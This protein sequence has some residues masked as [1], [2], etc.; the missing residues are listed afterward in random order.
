[1]RGDVI[2]EKLNRFIRKYYKNQLI[3]GGIYSFIALVSF[4]L[5]LN[6]I[7]YFGYNSSLVRSILFYLFL[8][9]AIL[10]LYFLIIIPLLRLFNLKKNLSHKD[11]ARIIGEHFPQIDDKLLNLLQLKDISLDEPS[12]ILEASIEQKT[13]ELS[14]IAFVKA[15]DFKKNKKYVKWIFVVVL[16]TIVLSLVFPNFLSE[17]TKRYI[18]YDK[19]F[20]KP[21]PFSFVLLNKNLKVLKNEDIEILVQIKG[22]YLVEEVDIVIEGNIF[23][24]QKEKKD[25]FSYK[26]KNI[27]KNSYFF[28]QASGFESKKYKI[29][30]NPKPILRS[31]KYRIIPPSYTNIPPSQYADLTN[32][33]I[34]KGS[35]V[36]WKAVTSTTKEVFFSF[37][38]K[39]EVFNPDNNDV[40]EFSKKILSSFS[41]NITTKNDYTTFNDSIEFSISIIEDNYPF[42]SVIK[43]QDS[44]FSDMVYFWGNIK[45]DYGFSRLEFHIQK[46]TSSIS[47][48]DNRENEIKINIPI[49]KGENIQEFYYAYNLNN[50]DIAQGEKA[51][52]YFEI[53]D[54]DLINGNKATRSSVFTFEKPSK[55]SIDSLISKN[56][57]QIKSSTS[58]NMNQLKQIQK[59]IEDINKRML[60]KKEVS[61][62]DKKELNSLIEKQEQVKKILDELSQ[63]IKENNRLDERISS[64]KSEEIIN[65]EKELEK[66]YEEL[67][68]QIDE[69][70]KKLLDENIKKE[71]IKNILDKLQS[72]NKHLEKEL[73]RALEMF[74]RLEVEKKM[75]ETINKLNSLSKEQKELSKKTKEKGDKD[76]LLKE[77]EK[78]N[79]EFEDIKKDIKDIKQKAEKLEETQK[80]E[81]NKEKQDSISAL[82]K[83]IQKQLEKNQ[84]NKASQNQNKAADKMEEMANSLSSQMEENNQEQLAE[85]VNEVRQL[86]KNLIK[87]SFSQ[88]ELI[89]KVRQTSVTDPLY[90]DIINKQNIIKNQ[91]K[92]ISD[93]LFAMSKR[94]PQIGSVVNKEVN[95]IEEQ[96]GLSLDKLLKYNQGFYN[97]YKNT[98]ASTNQQYSMTAM[99]NLSLLLAESL[100]KMQN[101]LKS[102]MK[103]KGKSKS[104]SQN[105][106]PSPGN[107]QSKSQNLKDIGKMQEALNKEM[108]RLKKE[109]DKQ[110]G[111]NKGSGTIGEGAQ[112][113]E[114]LVKMAAQ[115]EMIRKLMEQYAKE[116]K[117]KQGKG[118]REVDNFIKQMEQTEKDI[119]NKAI[120]NQT[121]MRQKNILTRMLEHEK[122]QKEKEKDN[123]RESKEGKEIFEENKKAIEE[124]KK[125][126]NKEIDTFKEVPAE[127]SPL[128]K[129]KTNDFF[130]NFGS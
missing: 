120:N 54:N 90:Q 88:E 84:N 67:S 20:E 73:D 29:E 44:L 80:I 98:Q 87:L 18:F 4:F 101:N 104:N 95:S 43:K 121:L 106:C 110:K 47:D 21:S 112:I 72:N 42:I 109:L 99:N 115:Q 10:I 30:V 49:N 129:E 13:K 119:V 126:K 65:R 66:L 50:L 24:M 5:L 22:D 93:S 58:G 94:Q 2:S 75:E 16:L 83:D 17:P 12:E 48:K 62:Q 100:D 103:S 77:Q 124:F 40:V 3:K 53:W 79:K 19:Y 55:E 57:S 96:I 63:K 6:L 117:E 113:N 15:I 123:K 14:P 86:L 38:D 26:I 122:A 33:T 28:F 108:E 107:T 41:Y 56:S 92:Q 45:D 34:P 125:I 46:N 82:Q 27:Q 69:E 11:A 35:V 1:M 91:F 68:K 81:E 7:E 111:K 8:I 39:Q 85:D 105:S 60:D 118:S 116:L 32:L 37:N 9:I 128:Y 36:F 52:Y 64:Q 31:L 114:E 78:I 76:S 25:L 61:W 70:F 97:T 23:T 59:E 89:D 51:N 127:F 102:M 130:Y 71:D 74:K